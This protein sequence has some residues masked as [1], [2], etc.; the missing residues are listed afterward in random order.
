MR[1]TWRDDT[2]AVTRRLIEA[3]RSGRIQTLGEIRDWAYHVSQ[4][5][6]RLQDIVLGAM[7][8]D[9]LQVFI[10]AIRE[11][12]QNGQTTLRV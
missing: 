6:P 3:A 12:E 8:I 1:L 7:T 11:R 5:P 2:E 9:N 10:E 4:L